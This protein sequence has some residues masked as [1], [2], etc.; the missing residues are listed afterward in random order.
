MIKSTKRLCLWQGQRLKGSE[1]SLIKT[2]DDLVNYS[3]YSLVE[4]PMLFQPKS[5]RKCC[6]DSTGVYSCCDSKIESNTLGRVLF[7]VFGLIIFLII[8]HIIG[9][10]YCK[11]F[12]RFRPPPYR[13]ESFG[14]DPIDRL[15][16]S[17]TAT[18]VPAPP[19][20]D[21]PPD[22]TSTDNIS[23]IDTSS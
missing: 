13:E 2:A 23:R 7:I 14:V 3:D 20:I 19:Y 6:L 10:C 16:F 17:R 21:K 4:C 22:Y 12:N 8:V 11:Y 5:F 9:M 18:P 1:L 15:P